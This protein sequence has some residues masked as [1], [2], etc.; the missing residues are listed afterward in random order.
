VGDLLPRAQLAIADPA[1]FSGY[2]LSKTHP[3][4]RHKARVFRSVLGFES[5]H[6]DDLR[7]SLLEGVRTTPIAKVEGGF[8]PGRWK[9]TID[10]EV[11]GAEGRR[12]IVR[13]IWEAAEAPKPPRLLTA[14][15]KRAPQT[16]TSA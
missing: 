5:R 1:R 13:S 4:G 11:Q 14:Y 7:T 6:S 8:E 2:L 15:V 10:I 16:P 3:K 9:C 12:A